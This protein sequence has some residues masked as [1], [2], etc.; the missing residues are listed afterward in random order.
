MS[1]RAD[2]ITKDPV[3]LRREVKR[4]PEEERQSACPNIKKDHNR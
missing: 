1:S 3:Q 4:W 2:R